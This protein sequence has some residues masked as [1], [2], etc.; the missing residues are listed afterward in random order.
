MKALLIDLD[1]TL[2]DTSAIEALRQARKWRDCVANF[3]STACFEGL[4]TAL[5]QLTA[6][7]TKI[8]VVTTSVS[9]YAQAALRH[10]NIPHH[11]LVSYHDA[12]PKPAPDP[13]LKAASLLGIDTAE[14]IGVGDGEPD[15]HSLK[16]AGIKALGAG[17]SPSLVFP[18]KWDAILSTPADL[19]SLHSI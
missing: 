19:V 13:Y 12:R 17:W 11:A 14:C 9:Y 15:L 10:H 1:G 2:I 18:D 3:G 7:G 4:H 16:S 6:A 5:Q 8:A